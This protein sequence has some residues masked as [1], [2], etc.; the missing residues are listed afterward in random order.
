[1]K[2]SYIK[3]SGGRCM[4]HRGAAGIFVCEDC[5]LVMCDRCYA[6]HEKK[7]KTHRPFTFPEKCDEILK[8]YEKW[9]NSAVEE[10]NDKI[11]AVLNEINQIKYSAEQL[12]IQLDYIVKDWAK[13]AVASAVDFK[14]SILKVYTEKRKA[15]LKIDEIR[16]LIKEGKY[17][18]VYIEDMENTTPKE[19]IKVPSADQICNVKE[20]RQNILNAINETFV[21]F[22]GGL[23]AYAKSENPVPHESSI[24]IIT[25]KSPILLEEKSE[26]ADELLDINS[27][28]SEEEALNLLQSSTMATLGFVNLS[29]Y[30]Y[31]DLI[32]HALITS[33]KTF[34]NIRGFYLSTFINSVHKNRWRTNY[35]QRR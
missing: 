1:M 18:T 26:P 20:L 10:A 23:S 11:E 31:T 5:D 3:E 14:G 4:M 28:A 19:E 22:A 35:R 29:N 27:N 7:F 33:L 6:L 9:Q 21:G 30:L 25:D 34:T 16:T 15:Y 24:S 8:K 13:K 2:K 12:L 32:A 17:W